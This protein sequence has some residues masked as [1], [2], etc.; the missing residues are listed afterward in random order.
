MKGLRVVIQSLNIDS[1]IERS[2]FSHTKR[3]LRFQLWVNPVFIIFITGATG[4]AIVY[5]FILDRRKYFKMEFLSKL[6]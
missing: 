5:I 2:K 3:L 6:D 4:E 1:Q